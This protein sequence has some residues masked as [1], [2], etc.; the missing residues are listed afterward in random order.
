MAA[1]RVTTDM[2]ASYAAILQL[3]ARFR[4]SIWKGMDVDDPVALAMVALI[5]NAD[6]LTRTAQVVEA[7]PRTGRDFDIVELTN[8]MINLGQ[9]VPQCDLA[10]SDLDSRFKLCLFVSGDEADPLRPRNPLVITG[11][12]E[13][14]GRRWFTAFSP[15][16][17]RTIEVDDSSPDCA[18]TGV[19]I[20]FVSYDSL[21]DPTSV[22]A[23]RA[24]KHSGFRVVLSR[25]R[26]TASRAPTLSASTRFPPTR[27]GTRHLVSSELS[28]NW[29]G[30]DATSGN[31]RSDRRGLA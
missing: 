17:G 28:P 10:L 31:R 30:N 15:R 29:S 6:L 9:N 8:A 19:V 22:E 11:I 4:A 21:G 7:L 20:L 3:F 24:T 2:S 14:A 23:R 12:R 16:E 27:S 26:S 13:E 5:V 18:T 25:F 1:E